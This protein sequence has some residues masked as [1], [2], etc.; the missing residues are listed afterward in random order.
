MRYRSKNGKT[1]M[2]S[3]PGGSEPESGKEKAAFSIREKM[4]RRRLP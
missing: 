2:E 4:P 3:G 1:E